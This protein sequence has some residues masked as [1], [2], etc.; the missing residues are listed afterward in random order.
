MDGATLEYMLGIVSA[1]VD[2]MRKRAAANGAPI[3]VGTTKGKAAL[4]E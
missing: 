4:S 1:A 2:E 3:A